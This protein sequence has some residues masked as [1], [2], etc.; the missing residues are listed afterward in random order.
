MLSVTLFQIIT[1]DKN[2]LHLDIL[3]SIIFEHFIG[4]SNFIHY[5]SKMPRSCNALGCK[6]NYRGE[7]YSQMI[8]FPSKEKDPDEWDRWVSAMPNERKQLEELKEIW[9]CRKHFNC[10][11]ISCRGGKKPVAPPS[12]FPGVPSSCFKQTQLKPRSTK[13]TSSD[14]RH[15][16]QL[17]LEEELDK[18]KDFENFKEQCAS[19]YRQFNVICNDTEDLYMSRT[20]P[21]GRRVLMFLHFRQIVSPFGFLYLVGVDKSETPL[22]K[23]LFSLQKNS[24]VSKWSQIDDIIHKIKHYEPSNDDHLQKVLESLDKMTDLHDSAFFQFLRNQLVLLLRSPKARRFQKQILVIAAE[25]F[26]ISASA[27][28]MLRRS[29][30]LALPGVTTL[31]K[32]LRGSFQ[33]ANLP[34]LFKELKPQQKLVNLLFDEVKLT[35]TLR[36]SAGHVLGYAKNLDNPEDKSSPEI[37]ATHALVLEIVCHYGGP[38]Y[39]LRVSPVAK[40]NAN[41]L[42]S[43]LQEAINTIIDSGGMIISL[44]CD[45][46]P[47]NQGCYRLF[48]GPGRVFVEHLG[49][50]M[51]FVFDY[52][53]IFKNIRNN[54]ITVQGKTLSFEM[55]GITYTASWADVE[56]LYNEDRGTTLRLTKLTHTAVFPKPLQRQ[57]VPLVCQVFHEKTV[58]AMISLQEKLK[59]NDGTIEFIRMITNWFKMLNV[60]DKYSAIRLRD[61]F[62]SPWTPNCE[63]FTH[64]KQTCDVIS[65]CAW[66]G[67]R[68]RVLKLTKATSEAFLVS[69]NANIEAAKYLLESKNFDYVLPGIFADEILEKFFGKTRMRNSG[70]FYIDIVDV[71]ASAKVTNLHA[72][73]KYDI[74]PKVHD[75]DVQGSSCE[76]CLKNI[77]EDDVEFLNDIS[78]ADTENLLESKDALKHKIVYIAGHLAHKFTEPE[79]DPENEISSEFLD[80]LNRGGLTLPTL[81]SVYFVH[82]AFKLTDQLSSEY[83]Q[84]RKYVSKLFSFI[85]APFSNNP[86]VCRTLA[87]IILKAFVLDKSDKEREQ[88][89][90]RRKEKLSLKQ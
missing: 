32:M 63:S 8:S 89:C 44:I 20:D 6:G 33:D 21:T 28:K 3:L 14:I 19:R 72:L 61:S 69:T 77:N 55:N 82:C 52:V 9:I 41:G 62:R 30:V 39:I 11:W 47:T 90:L 22:S 84:C 12:I 56:A 45:D 29:G 75:G 31:K 37:L 48:G 15:E 66:T 23:S 60:K 34:N 26:S 1:V 16:K 10:E 7:P 81:S 83:Y 24:L 64:L 36:Y 53:H 50:F 43:I 71:I 59:V 65:T 73:L 2:A 57:S 5:E 86:D 85:N 13:S 4:G 67:G 68:N 79:A 76:V 40:L 42:K 74:L 51:F 46:C 78:L 54:W 87:N 17:R 18:I 80:E 38:R 58:A 27:Y 70:N 25:L 88:G 49:V 35:Q